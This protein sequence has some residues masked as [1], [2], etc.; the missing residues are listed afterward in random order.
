MLLPGNWPCFC[1]RAVG[2]IVSLVAGLI[3][4]L[5]IASA[6]LMALEVVVGLSG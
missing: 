6:V 5:A 1:F 4:G 3:V 2:L